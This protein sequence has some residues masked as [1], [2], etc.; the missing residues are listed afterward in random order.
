MWCAR[1]PLALSRSH[2]HAAAL[3][4]TRA[5][6][7]QYVCSR[8]HRILAAAFTPNST[9]IMIPSHLRGPF[10]PQHRKCRSHASYLPPISRERNVNRNRTAALTPLQLSCL[11]TATFLL[12][13][14]RCQNCAIAVT[15]HLSCHHIYV[16]AQGIRSHAEALVAQL[17]HCRIFAIAFWYRSRAAKFRLSLI[18]QADEDYSVC[19]GQR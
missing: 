5:L 10:A 9:Y 1:R 8:C 15:L 16:T 14:S 6:T 18:L 7:Q 11:H 13:V 17:S 3:I 4:H 2:M 12:P 19:N